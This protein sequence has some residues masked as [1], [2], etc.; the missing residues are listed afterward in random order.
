MTTS[1]TEV[2]PTTIAPGI[3]P[4]AAARRGRPRTPVAEVPIGARYTGKVVGLSKFGAF[5]DIGAMT[6]GL[7]HM[8]ELPGKPVRS[9]EE[10]LK[11]GQEVEVWVKEVD[12]AK[13]RISLT[14]RTRPTHPMD[15]LSPGSVLTGKVTSIAAYGVFVNIDSDTEGLVHVSEMSSG[16]VQK[17]Q[18]IINVGDSVEVR[19]KE[20]DAARRRVSLSMVG[21]STDPGKDEAEA[22]AA[23]GAEAASNRQNQRASRAAEQA[24]VA[25]AGQPEEQM[26]TAMEL[27]MRRAMG[28]DADGTGRSDDSGRGKKAKASAGDLGDVYSRMLAEYRETKDG[29]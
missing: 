26:P 22:R 29:E 21:L 8:T 6:D 9:V 13:N 14:M 10:V 28:Q 18:D 27:A 16:F 15:S 19:V 11:S 24:E 7:V 12:A 5:V 17:P 1:E 23:A 4:E 25:S 3:D 2:T 20:V